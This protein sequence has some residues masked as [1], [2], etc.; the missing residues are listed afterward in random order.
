M[1]FLERFLWHAGIEHGQSAEGPM[2]V[3]LASG[4]CQFTAVPILS[5][6]HILFLM[7]EWAAWWPLMP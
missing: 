2:G 4:A 3:V 1:T 6:A 7:L 5:C